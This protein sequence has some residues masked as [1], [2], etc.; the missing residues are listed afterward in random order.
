MPLLIAVASE[1]T[2]SEAVDQSQHSDSYQKLLLA[3]LSSS[4]ATSRLLAHLVLA[5]LLQTLDAEASISLGVRILASLDKSLQTSTLRGIEHSE[6]PISPAYLQAV[7]AKPEEAQTSRMATISLVSSFCAFRRP[8]DAKI[9]WF[10]VSDFKTLTTTIYRHANSDSLPP[11]LAR[12]L[13]QH[14]FAVLREETLTFLACVWT[15]IHTS[16]PLRV[17]ALRHACAFA[18]SYALGTDFQMVVPSILVAFTAKNQ[19]IR[20]AAVALLKIVNRSASNETKNYYALDTFYGDQS[21]MSEAC[22]N[23]VDESLTIQTKCSY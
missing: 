21:G 17:A 6:D 14:L 23:L 5:S 22:I 15:D 10:G 11:A 4:T 16:E 13:L 20:E 9:D 12:K 2:R 18:K 8:S 1:L 19:A 7:Y 3:Q